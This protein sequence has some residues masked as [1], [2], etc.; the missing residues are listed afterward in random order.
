MVVTWPI[1][2]NLSH[3]YHSHLCNCL[4]HFWFS[5]THSMCHFICNYTF[6]HIFLFCLY[7]PLI[8][9]C[10]PSCC[11]SQFFHA[12]HLRMPT[13][14]TVDIF[15][16]FCF[17]HPFTSKLNPKNCHLWTHVILSIIAKKKKNQSQGKSLLQNKKRMLT[18]TFFSSH[19]SI[20]SISQKLAIHSNKPKKKKK[21]NVLNS[22]FSKKKKSFTYLLFFL[23]LVRQ[24][25]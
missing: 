6:L 17:L 18:H 11:E 12:R 20:Y 13:L 4:F 7:F 19:S 15:L 5:I 2:I 14:C 1:T 24:L 9:F 21:R 3:R 22:V 23:F 25:H 8:C 10:F 16:F